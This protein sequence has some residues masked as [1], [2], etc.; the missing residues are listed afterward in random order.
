MVEGKTAER[1]YDELRG[2][3]NE[4]VSQFQKQADQAKVLSETGGNNAI[5]C[6]ANGEALAWTMAAVWLREMLDPTVDR[7]VHVQVDAL[8][9]LY[10]AHIEMLD[11]FAKGTDGQRA[12]GA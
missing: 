4:L 7:A 9:V 12:G 3:L 5:M 1:A 8:A 10:K 2:G 6:I 11:S